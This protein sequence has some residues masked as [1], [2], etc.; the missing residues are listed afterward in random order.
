MPVEEQ[1]AP[2]FQSECSIC[3]TS[4]T[5]V[6]L[7]HIQPNTELCGICFFQDRRMIDFELWNEPMEATE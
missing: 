4:P 2:D 7:E 6:V 5:V 1:F 3:G